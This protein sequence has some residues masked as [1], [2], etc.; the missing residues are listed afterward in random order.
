[1][2]IDGCKI[3]LN[4]KLHTTQLE[5]CAVLEILQDFWIRVR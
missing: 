4:K 5:R 2:A 3:A 1:M